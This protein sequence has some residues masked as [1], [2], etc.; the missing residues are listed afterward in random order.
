[1]RCV[2]GCLAVRAMERT[3]P[4]HIACELQLVEIVGKTVYNVLRFKFW[5][6]SG[7][8]G[9]PALLES[10]SHMCWSSGPSKPSSSPGLKLHIMCIL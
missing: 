9:I 4:P 2:D 8:L 1:M 7:Q 10:R 6:P 3:E 5:A